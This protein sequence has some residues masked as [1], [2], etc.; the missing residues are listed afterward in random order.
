[1]NLGPFTVQTHENNLWVEQNAPRLLQGKDYRGQ[2]K[3]EAFKS[4]IAEAESY[5]ASQT[6]HDVFFQIPVSDVAPKR[7]GGKRRGGRRSAGDGTSLFQ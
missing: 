5:I 1:M 2:T 6:L 4:A 3:Q 7:T